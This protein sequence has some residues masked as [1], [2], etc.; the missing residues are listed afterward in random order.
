VEN[1]LQYQLQSRS[2]SKRSSDQDKSI[3]HEVEDAGYDI[4]GI[5]RQHK[6]RIS[7]FK[8]EHKQYE[9]SN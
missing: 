1:L 3:N 7:K 8:K 5:R 4:K 9:D 2:M 6:K